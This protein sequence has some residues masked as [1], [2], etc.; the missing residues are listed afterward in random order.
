[1][2][3]LSLTSVL[4]RG[5][6]PL[7]ACSLFVLAAGYRPAAA[8]ATLSLLYGDTPGRPISG[9]FSFNFPR[10]LTRWAASFRLITRIFGAKKKGR[11]GEQTTKE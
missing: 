8:T 7:A 10:L 6:A 2:P 4:R 3:C 5:E 9:V 11:R 1:M